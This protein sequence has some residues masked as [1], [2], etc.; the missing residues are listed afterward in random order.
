MSDFKTVHKWS[1]VW[2]FEKEEAWLS[3]MAESGWVLSGV[4]FCTYHFAKSEPGEYTI[5]LEMHAA[6]AAYLNFMS[7]TG[8]EYVGRVFQWIYFRRKSSYGSFDLFSDI[9]SRI[10]HLDNIGKMLLAIGMAN[11]ILGLVNSFNPVS[12]VGWL[13]LLCC[14]VLMYGLGRI[15]GKKEALEKERMLHE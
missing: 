14:T 13:N 9:D 10:R 5:R 3:E 8:A 2:D 6:D 7:E 4:G 12:N 11:L 15:H 1:W